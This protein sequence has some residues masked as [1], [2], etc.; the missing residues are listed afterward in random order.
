VTGGQR[1]DPAIGTRACGA[2]VPVLVVDDHAGFRRVIRMV[3]DDAPLRFDVHLVSTGGA[4]L[5]FLSREPPFS[6]APHPA[7]MVLDFRLPDMLA[8]EVLQ[9]LRRL[10]TLGDIPVLVL[11]AAGWEEDEASSIEAGAQGF[12]VK[13]SNAD[14]LLDRI[15]EFC[16]RHVRWPPASS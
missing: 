10:P 11:S 14:V 8:P 2:A 1:E 13:P 3:L 9:R 16:T 6:Q 7:F 12:L 15:E 5:R 4:A